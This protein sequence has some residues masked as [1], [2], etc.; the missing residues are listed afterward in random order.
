MTN[1][2]ALSLTLNLKH[3]NNNFGKL[4]RLLFAHFTTL[5]FKMEKLSFSQSTHTQSHND[6]V[7]I[8]F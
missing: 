8:Y 3:F 5:F 4:F 6:K 7:K 1:S 2:D